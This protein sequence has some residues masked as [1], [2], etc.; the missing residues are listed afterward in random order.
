MVVKDNCSNDI[1]SS[2]LQFSKNSYGSEGIVSPF[3]NI[4]TLQ[5]S[6]NSYGGEGETLNIKST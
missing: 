2:E 1:P 5:F 6:K 3:Y 4:L